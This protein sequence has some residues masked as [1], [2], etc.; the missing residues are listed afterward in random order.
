MPLTDAQIDRFS[1]QIIL[2]QIGGRGQERLLQSSVAIAGSGELAAIAALYLA[3]AGIG[4][5]ALHGTTSDLRPDLS[6]LSPD[7][8]VTLPPGRLGSVGADVLVACNAILAEIDGAATSGRS[9]VAGGTESHRGWVV[10]ADSPDTC[11]S[12]VARGFG[13]RELAPALGWEGSGRSDAARTTAPGPER[14]RLEKL[15]IAALQSP[16]IGVIGSL[17]SLA[18][19][20]LLLEIGEPARPVWLEFDG[21]GATLTEHPI[22]RAPDCP[23]CST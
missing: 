9:L 23:A 2:P 15:G 8:Q 1:R 10:V 21:A 19:L 3:G 11:A 17:M 18:V 6:N 4:S 5:M 7:V 20:K 14:Q 22:E 16:A 13:V 12:C